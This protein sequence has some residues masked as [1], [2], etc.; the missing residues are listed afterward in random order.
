MH[1]SFSL[2]ACSY[3]SLRL[4]AAPYASHPVLPLNAFDSASFGFKA[5]LNVLPLPS[6]LEIERERDE[7]SRRSIRRSAGRP[8]L[9]AI[10]DDVP[11]RVHVGNAL[12]CNS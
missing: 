11:V 12:R 3:L 10:F 4:F 2:R 9:G 5:P 6:G 1:I 8:A 7:I